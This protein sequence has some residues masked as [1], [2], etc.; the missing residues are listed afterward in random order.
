MS[1]TKYVAGIEIGGT[2]AAVAISDKIGNLVWMKKGI[3]TG[4]DQTPS[5]AVEKFSKALKS[6][7]Y[8]FKKIGIASFGP[9]DLQKGT[10][11]N[12]PKPGWGKFPLVQEVKKHFPGKEIILETDVNAPAYCE[13]VEYH[14]EDP[15]ITSLAYITVG[16]GVG[17]GLYS[18]KKVYHGS[19]HPEFGHSKIQKRKNDNFK[20]TCPFHGD[21]VEGLVSSGSISKR[22][23]ITQHDIRYLKPD[24]PI[25]DLYSDYLGQTAANA[26]LAYSLDAFV[27][28]GGITTADGRDF[29]YKKIQ[30]YC[31]KYL[32]GYIKSPRILRPHYGKDSGLIGACAVAFQ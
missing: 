32:N 5:Q 23:G 30:Q 2:S 17:L 20:G 12:T 26:A 15:S 11:G 18:D 9:L 3:P 28:G 25:W 13:F 21:C 24:S 19:M 31:D 29:L 16:T 1:L 22:L 27:I 10:M 8:D 4:T 7:G 14:K 6:S